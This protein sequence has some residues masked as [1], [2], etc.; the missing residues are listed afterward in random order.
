MVLSGLLNDG[1]AGLAEIKKQ[2]GIAIVQEPSTALF[3]DMPR[4]AIQYVPNVDYILSPHEIGDRI[5]QLVE[6]FGMNE[7][8]DT[9]C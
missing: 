5:V 4:C 8:G 7:A 3:S 2:G 6:K 1:A 9:L